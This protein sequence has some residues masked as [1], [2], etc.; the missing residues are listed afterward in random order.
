MTLVLVTFMVFNTC[1]VF[2]AA[3]KQRV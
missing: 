3:A 1:T 2:I